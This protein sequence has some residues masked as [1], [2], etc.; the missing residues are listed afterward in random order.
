MQASPAYQ[1][2]ESPADQWQESPADQ[3]QQSPDQQP[4]DQ[5]QGQQEQQPSPP[6]PDQWQQSPDQQQ[7][8][9]PLDQPPS[10]SDQPP[11]PPPPP[12]GSSS[13]WPSWLGRR[14]LLQQADQGQQQQQE[15]DSQPLCGGSSAA[16]CSSVAAPLPAGARPQGSTLDSDLVAIDLGGTVLQPG[17]LVALRFTYSG[18]LGSGSGLYRS[19]PFADCTT[20]SGGGDGSSGS[21]AATTSCSTA[22]LVATQLE[23]TYA[24]ALLPCWDGPGFKA[25][26]SLTLRLPLG[27]TAL[28]NTPEA[29]RWVE[30]SSSSSSD[31]GGSGGGSSGGGDG[32]SGSNAVQVVQFQTTPV[33][34]P[35][36][37]A[38]AAGRLAQYGAGGSGASPA[39]RLW[40]VPGREGELALAAAV[41]PA[42]FA[43]YLEYTGVA[44]PLSKVGFR[45]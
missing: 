38:L 25:A 21:P 22:V 29:A 44:Q 13:W 5:Q 14:R 36:L 18:Q 35:Y 10:P 1:G 28:S 16:A 7:Q 33:M 30:S 24:R 39:L 11:Q 20:A 45:V 32:S 8:E 40:A 26:F 6:S 37:L 4:S 42:A 3:W 19:A 43:H 31:A 9:Q 41:A 2:Q 23:P 15:W 12:S 34:S 27:L 17:S